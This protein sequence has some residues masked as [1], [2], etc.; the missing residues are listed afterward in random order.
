MTNKLGRLVLIFAIV[1]LVFL[2]FKSSSVQAVS[3][4]RHKKDGKVVPGQLIVKFRSAT[5]QSQAQGFA[6]GSG[7][8]V[9]K[10]LLNPRT[11]LL[12]FNT[13]ESVADLR[14]RLEKDPNVL[15]AE[16]NGYVRAMFTPNDRYY[17]RQWNLRQLNMSQAWNKTKGKGSVVAVVDTGVAYLNITRGGVTY[18]RL[19]DFN[20]TRF[21]PGYNFVNNN[22]FPLDDNQHGS[23]VAGTIA[24][25]TGNRIGV[26]GVAYHASIMPVKVLD[27][28]GFGTFDNV[29]DGIRWAANHG[30]HVINLSLGSSSPSNAMREAVRYARYRKNVVVVAAAGNSGTGNLGYPAAYPSVV[31]VAATDYN[32][33][34]A[35]YSQYGQGLDISAPGGD[36]SADINRDGFV[37]GILQQTIFENNP[38]RQGYFYF[39][40]T[41]MAAPHVSGVAALVRSSG[42][43]KASAIIGAIQSSATDLGA[44]GYDTRYGHGLVNAYMA[45][46]YRRLVTPRILRPRKNATLKGGRVTII[47]W[48]RRRAKKLQYHISYSKNALAT[49]TF[50]DSYEKGRLS[51]AYT[52]SG[53]KLWKLTSAQSVLGTHS[54]KAGNIRNSQITQMSIKKLF[55]SSATITFYYYVSSEQGYD[56]FDFYVDDSRKI[57]ASG[58]T[59]WKS[60]SIPVSAGEHTLLWS[61]SKD[62][63][64]KAGAD[65]VYVDNLRMPNISRAK[66][67][68]VL[69]TTRVGA[70]YY[71]WKVP[72]GKTTTGQVRVRPYNGS[73]G[74]WD[75]SSGTFKVN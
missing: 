1:S 20:R 61:Y 16:P 60:V 65:T 68:N 19:S 62:Y 32:K 27:R 10:K 69:S 45:T 36:T 12:K 55:K 64:V 63:S 53:N 35:W 67:R 15:Y 28:D 31:S 70:R 23:H 6:A 46:R 59:G 54:T 18:R 4:P 72:R 37:D 25:S 48:H 3:V 52:R 73:Y 17:R 29:A 7:G 47:K 9:V 14:V 30:A 24:Q 41:S 74:N 66:W 38:R 56:F 50:V 34:L 71:R 26:A 51:S 13:N 2:G 75:Y 57:H 40:G 49:G 44:P 58:N 42:R 22:S 21:K 33:T 39:Q 5:G 8:R 43:R 11:W